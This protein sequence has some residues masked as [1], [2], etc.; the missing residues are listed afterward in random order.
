VCNCQHTYFWPNRQMRR[1]WRQVRCNA[2]MSRAK[3][4]C[5]KVKKLLGDPVML[6]VVKT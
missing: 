4:S 1:V 6:V 5:V 2:A 3:F